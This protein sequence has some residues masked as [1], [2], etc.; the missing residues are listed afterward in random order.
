M[1]YGVGF[2]SVMHHCIQFSKKKIGVPILTRIIIFANSSSSLFGI[3]ILKMSRDWQQR[4]MLDLNFGVRFESVMHPCVQFSKKWCEVPTLNRIIFFENQS[5]S[6]YLGIYTRNV[7][8]LTPVELAI[9]ELRWKFQVCDTPLRLWFLI[10]SLSWY[11]PLEARFRWSWDMQGA[12]GFSDLRQYTT[13]S[14]QC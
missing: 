10:F 3:Y 1:N 13:V 8:N 12:P 7:W 5:S 2:K 11:R 9:F 6:F 14:N 4:S